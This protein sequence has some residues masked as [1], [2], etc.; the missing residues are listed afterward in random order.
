MMLVQQENIFEVVIGSGKPYTIEHWLQCCFDVIS[1]DWRD[2]ITLQQGF[3]AEY[4]LLLSNPTLVK[5]MG[6]NPT[7]DIEEL[8]RIMVLPGNEQTGCHNLSNSTLIHP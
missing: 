3:H 1:K 4:S 8:A 2:Y 7:V 5:Q 6:W